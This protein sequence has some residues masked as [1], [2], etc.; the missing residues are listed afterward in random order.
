MDRLG[1]A[2]HIRVN[3][4][5]AAIVLAAGRSTRMGR[6]KLLLPL[7]GRPLVSYAV[8]AASASSADPVIVVVGYQAAEI[9]AA[10]PAGRYRIRI[11][12]DY[13]R[14]MAGSLVQG[15]AALAALPAGSRPLAGAIILLADQP[16]VSTRLINRL[17]ESAYAAPSA[18]LATTYAGQR[19][20][21]VYFPSLLWGELLQI[22]GDEGGR[23]VIAKHPDLVRTLDI[24]EPEPG[25]D[26]DRAEEYDELVT[27]WARYATKFLDGL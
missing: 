6:H 4:S 20:T 17:L 11:N 5:I 22:T 18:I 23:S 25:L 8:E 19:S 24:A 15:I 13:S 21:P 9:Q 12:H 7:G 27:N 2:A 3:P 1:A 26:V 14:G 16:L 10:L